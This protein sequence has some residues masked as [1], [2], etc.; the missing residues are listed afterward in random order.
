MIK[1]LFTALLAALFLFSLAACGED[2]PTADV[3]SDS[4][5]STPAPAETPEPV[6]DETDPPG[7]SIA[8]SFKEQTLFFPEGATAENADYILTYSLPLFPE[9]DARNEAVALYE[10]E[11]IAR[12]QEERLPLADR[13]EGEIAPSTAVAWELFTAE[14]AGREYTNLLLFETVTFGAGEEVLPHALVLDGAGA[15]L[16]FAALSG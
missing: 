9:G 7:E 5:I 13:A 16:T 8:A 6:Q 1:R 3:G 10:A 2:I 14:L 11:L 4:V 15:E 12:V